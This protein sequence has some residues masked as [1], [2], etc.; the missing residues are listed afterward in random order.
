MSVKLNGECSSPVTNN[1]P[2]TNGIC[3]SGIAVK[4]P[5]YY[6]YISNTIR[7]TKAPITSGIHNISL[8]LLKPTIPT[9]LKILSQYLYLA[10][11]IYHLQITLFT[12]PFVTVY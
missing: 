9:T 6:R 1:L 12:F 10:T 5:L 7:L 2:F 11:S 8:M 4:L 3:Q